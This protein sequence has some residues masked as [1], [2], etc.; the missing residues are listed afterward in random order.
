M[1]ESDTARTSAKEQRSQPGSASA[2]LAFDV[3][4]PFE[5]LTRELVASWERGERRPAEHFLNRNPQLRDNTEAAVALVYEEYCLRQEL[6]ESV[7]PGEYYERFAKWRAELELLFH[8]HE[9]IDPPGQDA[10]FPEVGGRLGEFRLLAELGRGAQ[11]QVYL[12]SQPLLGDRLVVLKVTTE[13][14]SEHLLLSRLQ[15][16]HI[17]PLY[18]VLEE[19]Q[20]NLFAFCM[21]Y[22]GG[23]TLEQILAALHARPVQQRSGREILDVLAE[24]YKPADATTPPAGRSWA[25]L[26]SAPYAGAVTWIGAC[27]AEAL[28]YMHERGLLHLDVKPSNVLVAGDGQPMLIDLHLAREPLQ[29]GTK[30]AGRLGGTRCYMSPEQTRA[31]EAAMIAAT[32]PVDVDSRSDIYS[33]GLV[34]YEALSG[35]TPEVQAHPRQ[36]VPLSNRN[37]NVSPGLSDI[38]GRCLMRE[39]RDR[40]ADASSLAADLRRHL[41]HLPLQVAGNRSLTERWRKWRRRRPYGLALLTLLLLLIFGAGGTCLFGWLQV[42]HRIALAESRL[43]EASR[44]DAAGNHDEAL[45]ALHEARRETLRVPGSANLR[46]RLAAEIET[47]RQ[48]ELARRVSELVDRLRPLEGFDEVPP[49]QIEELR[50]RCERVWEKRDLLNVTG[51]GLHELNQ[52]MRGDLLDLGIL[53][54]GLLGRSTHEIASHNEALRILDETQ[55]LFGSSAALEVQ[56]YYHAD[57]AGL[58]ELASESRRRAARLVPRT[59]WEHQALG[60]WLLRQGQLAQAN[61]HFQAAIERQ[62]ES[63][64]AHFYHA[65]CAYRLEQPSV[66]VQEMGICIALSPKRPEC[67]YNRALAL[68]ALGRREEALRDLD[69]ALELSP[70]F[71]PAIRQR[72]MLREARSPL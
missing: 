5:S 23:T 29:A 43:R 60:R 10:A 53:F 35:W 11:G 18:G 46:Q 63:F 40:Y 28:A 12:A 61:E 16:T 41:T 27:L 14:G 52:A 21:P 2:R 19:P 22:V 71:P 34:L 24:K 62:P 51:S 31:V 25:F 17:V 44:L 33:L 57:A 13:R 6:G 47:V 32:V 72:A 42:Q 4:D 65:A 67:Y 48:H 39:P 54:A 58:A 1:S 7:A 26:E 59:S 50:T 49:S 45:R 68:A 64:W 55:R 3:D 8:C 56:R 37:P 15:H 38:V 30:V 20:R 36:F 9:L 66:A 70:G 69:R